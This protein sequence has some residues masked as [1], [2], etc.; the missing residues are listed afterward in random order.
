[1]SIAY[2]INQYPLVSHSFIRREI[3]AVESCG[4]RVERFSIRR[5]R[6]RDIEAADAVERA[7][8]KVIL[9]HGG[10]EALRSLASTATRQ[11]VLFSRVLHRT[12]RLG[13][14]SDRGALRHFAYLA[15]AA[16]LLEWIRERRLTHIHAHFATNS[17]MVAM[18]ARVLGGPP[19]SFTAHG[20]DDFDRARYL[21]LRDKIARASFVTSVSDFGRSQLYRWADIADWSKVH[22]IRPFMDTAALVEAPS[23]VP[24]APRLVCTARFDEQK[25]HLLLLEAVERLLHDG[26]ACELVLLGDGP[27]RGVIEHQI[28]QRGLERHVR[29]VGWANSGQVR[30]HLRSARALVLASFAENLPSAIM[31][32]FLVGRPAISTYV[33]GI[34]ELI[35][36]E[37]SGWLVPP[38][39]VD[40]LVCAMRGALAAPPAR[41]EEM[42]RAGRRR[43]SEWHASGAQVRSLVSLFGAAGST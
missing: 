38:G 27:L 3:R 43:V 18:L 41:L 35:E 19:F 39:S 2:L 8:T 42:G 26:T 28:R 1:M 6:A 11:P 4:I 7:R 23:D 5:T 10:R 16:L 32:A 36:P 40:S 29:I 15:E 30:E 12:T 31:E 24:V 13:W 33:G 20:P 21:G 34:P 22:V 25:G 17:T 14:R 9:D 37:K